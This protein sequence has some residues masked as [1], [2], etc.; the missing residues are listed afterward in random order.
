MPSGQK[1]GQADEKK[2]KDKSMSFSEKDAKRVLKKHFNAKDVR[3]L[4]KY[5]GSSE[6]SEVYIGLL[7]GDDERAWGAG[8]LK[9]DEERLERETNNC[10][11][12]R[13]DITQDA[14]L[15]L[16]A[17][18]IIDKTTKTDLLI[19][20]GVHGVS[21]E[22][23][24][25][26]QVF[27]AFAE[28]NI[29][30]NPKIVWDMLETAL[31]RLRP[32]YEKSDFDVGNSFKEIEPYKK[33]FSEKKIDEII[34]S[35]NCLKIPDF[36]R[37][38]DFNFYEQLLKASPSPNYMKL[39]WV[40]GDLNPTNILI[41]NNE[42]Y[43]IDFAS[44][45][46][47]CHLAFDFVSIETQLI[48][49]LLEAI[50]LQD[51]Y[52]FCQELFFLTPSD[53]LSYKLTELSEIAEYNYF[54]E[55]VCNNLFAVLAKLRAHAFNYLTQPND[56]KYAFKDYHGALAL[57]AFAFIRHKAIIEN[58]Y[59]KNGLALCLI[60]SKLAWDSFNDKREFLKQNPYRGLDVFQEEDAPFYF[61]RSKMIDDLQ[62]AV[63][64]KPFVA[65]IGAS[66]SGKSSLV[67]AGLV[68]KLR[69]SGQWLIAKFRPKNQPFWQ[70]VNTL[71]PLKTYQKSDSKEF[72]EEFNSFL[73]NIET[74]QGT[75]SNHLRIIIERNRSKRILLIVD[76]FEELYTS[77][78]NEELQKHFVDQLVHAISN[79]MT[80]L[81]TIRADFMG[82]VDS[83]F[84][85]LNT[86]HPIFLA[87]M[88]EA[89]LREVIEK[90][91]K[92]CRI[93]IES[94]LT[95]LMLGDLKKEPG[96]L[97]LLEFA[98]TELWEKYRSMTRNSYNLMGG[99]NEAL[100]KHA[101]KVYAG[102]SPK[103]QERVRHIFVQLVHPGQGTEDTRQIARLE[104]L[105]KEEDRS[106]IAK[107]A[108]E[109]LIVTNKEKD[110]DL[111]TVEI[112][113][114]ALIR[115]WQKLK[116]WMNEDRDFRVWQERLRTALRQWESCN[117]DEGA[118][119][120]GVPLAEAEENLK[121]YEY[122]LPSE[123]IEYIKAGIAF[124]EKEKA[125]KERARQER[126]K[127]QKRIAWTFGIAMVVALILSGEIWLKYQES[128]RNLRQAQINEVEALSQSAALFL[129][130]DKEDWRSLVTAVKAEKKARQMDLPDKLKYQMLKIFRQ[131]LEDWRSLVAAVKAGKKARQM[132]L[133]DELKYQM[134]KIFRQ[135]LYELHEVT[136]L[137][138]H[139]D[140]VNS[141][142]FSSDGKLLA[143]GS[144]D[145]TI[146]LWNIAEKKEIA[147]LK[148]H[149]KSVNSVAFRYDG[150][151]LA[152]GSDDNS[153]KLWDIAE[154]KEITQLLGH[155]EKVNSVAFSPDGKLLVSGSH[156][157]SIKLWNIAE[158]R[159]IS[160]LR[161]HSGRIEDIAFSPDGKLL[162]SVGFD[163]FMSIKLWN[164]TEKKEI[165]Q[166]SSQLSFGAATRVA[167]SPDGKLL[168]SGSR[169]KN[170]TLWDIAEKKQIAQLTGHTDIV[171]SVAF[172]PNGKLLASGSY[173]NT[174]RLWDI[175]EKKEIEQLIGDT[176][177]VAFSPDGKLIASGKRDGT[178]RI[179]NIEDKRQITRLTDH[180]GRVD[181]VAFS[182]D[183]KL[184]ASAKAENYYDS[185]KLWDIASKREIE[186]LKGDSNRVRNVAFSPDGKLLV[187]AGKTIKFWNIASKREIE[188]LIG[189]PYGVKNVAFS[190][191]GKLLA[192]TGDLFDNNTIRLWDI[193][194]KKQIA[195]LREHT[196]Q[197]DSVAFSPDGKLLA[198]AGCKTLTLWNIAEK[199]QIAQL[200]SESATSVAFSPDGK[201]LASAG[202]TIKLWDIASKGE[203]V[204]L[205]GHSEIV[206]SVA[207]SPDG[208]LLASGSYDKTVKLWDIASKRELAQLTGH[209]NKIRNVAFS[210]DGKLL[211]SESLDDTVKLWNME[212]Y[213]SDLDGLLKDACN[214]LHPYL[215]DID[216]PN[217]K[218]TDR[219]LCDDIREE[220]NTDNR[221]TDYNKIIEINDTELQYI[222]RGDAYYDKGEYDKAVDDYSK[223]IEINDQ[224]DQAYM[225]RGNTYFN[226]GDY[227]NAI[228]DYSKVIEI[229]QKNDMAY[230][231]RGIAYSN[232]GE[233]EKAIYDYSKAIEINDQNDMAYILQGDA[234][235]NKGEYDKAV[236]DYSK[237]IEI[238][239][240]NDTAYINRGNAY[241]NKGEYDKAI[242]DY[243]KAIE[244]NPKNDRGYNGISWLL[245]TCPDAKYRN[246][247]KA[248]EFAKKA[249]ELNPNIYEF[250]DTLAAAYAEAGQFDEAV[251]AQEKTIEML[252]E[253][254]KDIPEFKERL[255]LYKVGKPWREKQRQ[256]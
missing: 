130:K 231:N 180:I 4:E 19:F 246:G 30:D 162:A 170:I 82:K 203:I 173:D 37:P 61:G 212:Y 244:I 226:K 252:G 78:S 103:E 142:A 148:G 22:P 52:D 121:K 119:L 247:A 135:V 137:K 87:P 184:L 145:N 38:F 79:D 45:K 163:F 55:P 25:N 155:T 59:P 51:T 43:I 191:D 249:I 33:I 144:H 100:S 102:F 95:E 91:A 84:N 166:S 46:A 31:E 36:L 12:I 208:K 98:L 67:F 245:A 235:N 122:E 123:E 74:N 47:A 187:S 177:Y 240:K 53:L 20:K 210:P 72:N 65:I 116:N 27:G 227:D 105:K 200:S 9:I 224:N 172:S 13:K 108:D 219:G 153:I 73:K 194:K 60:I 175:A 57:Y 152:S 127:L 201:L 256:P 10:K 218:D 214:R 181:S 186:E 14:H 5:T 1:N 253:K 85:A 17:E 32:L 232:K 66:G 195:P 185:I 241:Y 136:N 220:N 62:K 134:L 239:P 217:L 41:S 159:E 124:R 131:M 139:T 132:D 178:I 225:K 16:E 242:D 233:Y 81:I 99:V 205:T 58:R 39:S 204:Q 238:N 56:Q 129:E 89:E 24:I 34:N 157:G 143:S 80:L 236:D 140:I 125:E 113:H 156:D 198:S 206:T 71:M 228:D 111:E 83:L 92:K 88:K 2:S 133:P 150:K 141:F 128:N 211:A 26:P 209:S 165:A 35:M 106:L 93:R 199:K 8:V 188:E 11:Y 223:A 110:K 193:K 254:I 196:N 169:D 68:P 154:K 6:R 114:E 237:A 109:R 250:G 120:R 54:S 117:K 64:T 96:S 44:S 171:T 192:S 151:L 75:L 190:P 28:K 7:I 146:K 189:H 70:L 49:G 202:S 63:E 222:K 118:L 97:P 221:G 167:F 94:G 149:S 126:E 76:Q 42:P 69:E 234:Y 207:F 230:L 40:H 197:I 48:I 23:L 86:Y 29:A 179:C 174:I 248:I 18:S 160:A 3:S 112:V 183:G 251:K 138:G 168:A 101:E 115:N 164:I 243:N 255:N 213:S 107:L 15:L 229:N 158:K 147:T 182:P 176:N 104:Q 90:P 215:K 216:D 77:N 21:G 50:P 161:G